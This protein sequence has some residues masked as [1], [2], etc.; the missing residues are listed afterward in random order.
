MPMSRVLD[1][2]QFVALPE[3]VSHSTHLILAVIADVFLQLSSS[4]LVPLI[5][6]GFEFLVVKRLH[7]FIPKRIM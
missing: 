7:C 2:V 6:R 1:I 5:K 4:G 3:D